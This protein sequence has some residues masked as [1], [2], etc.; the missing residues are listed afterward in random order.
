M[1]V[2]YF[3]YTNSGG[4][5]SFGDIDGS[6]SNPILALAKVTDGSGNPVP[7]GTNVTVTPTVFESYTSCP[8]PPVV[9][10]CC[11]NSTPV[12]GAPVTVQTRKGMALFGSSFGPYTSNK[13]IGWLE[14]GGIITIT[15]N[16][17]AC[18]PNG[19]TISTADW[20]VGNPVLK[21][22]PMNGAILWEWDPPASRDPRVELEYGIS[23]VPD[24]GTP[25][26]Q[27]TN[28]QL[29]RTS[30]ISMGLTNGVTYRARVQAFIVV[31]TTFPIANPR[32]ISNIAEAV[33]AAVERWGGIYVAA[34]PGTYGVA[35]DHRWVLSGGVGTA[36]QDDCIDSN[37]LDTSGG[38]HT[39]FELDSTGKRLVCRNGGSFTYSWF[40]T[41]SGPY[42]YGNPFTPVPN[43]NVDI[44]VLVNGVSIGKLYNNFTLNG[45]VGRGTAP[46]P[47][48]TPRALSDGDVVSFRGRFLSS[49]PNGM[50]A[51]PSWIQIQ[52]SVP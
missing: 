42:D 20:I 11:I 3:L 22:T 37:V 44:E 41:T 35:M 17:T 4:S 2:E 10:P 24:P 51:Y 45:S 12:S 34:E 19:G 38:L 7:N 26:A 28:M 49:P 15:P 6:V 5:S 50:A 46:P 39:E 40:R 30:F 16:R 43:V 1:P 13:V 14:T 48:D 29:T 33:P 21:G 31:G 9:P 36:M 47:L 18:F 27:P 52:R 8:S 32:S 25:A 23:V